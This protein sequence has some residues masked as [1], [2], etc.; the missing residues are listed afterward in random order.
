MVKLSV[1]LSGQMRKEMTNGWG[2]A[3]LE[4]EGEECVCMMEMGTENGWLHVYYVYSSDVHANVHMC[5][6]L[7]RVSQPL[8]CPYVNFWQMSHA[9]THI[10][11]HTTSRVPSWGATFL[12]VVPGADGEEVNGERWRRRRGSV[13]ARKGPA[14]RELHFPPDR[15]DKGHRGLAQLR[16]ALSNPQ[17]SRPRTASGSQLNPWTS[18]SVLHLPAPA[19]RP[20]VLGLSTNW[21]VMKN[22][23]ITFA[24]MFL[25]FFF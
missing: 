19:P 6:V 7:T 5:K 20:Q 22:I 10:N 11:T 15:I 23:R 2:K 8:S 3:C 14:R 24:G 21:V 16:S 9:H 12:L 18:A 17:S 25:F 4:D 1:W 13:R